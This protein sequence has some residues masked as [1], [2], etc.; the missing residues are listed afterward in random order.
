MNQ[1]TT[2]VALLFLAACGPLPVDDVDE[3]GEDDVATSIF[4]D[5]LRRV[6]LQPQ[7]AASF[8][9]DVYSDDELRTAITEAVARSTTGDLPQGFGVRIMAPISFS[10]PYV[11]PA[12]VPGFSI[13]GNNILMTP[14]ASVD[15]VFVVETYFVRIES[16]SVY[17]T[18]PAIVVGALVAT[19]AGT[20]TTGGSLSMS[21]M[22][23][24]SAL[25]RI[26]SSAGQGGWTV[27]QCSHLLLG[28]PS[29]G[30]G[31]SLLGSDSHIIQGNSTDATEA[32]QWFGD[33]VVVNGNTFSG[34]ATGDTGSSSAVF[35]GNVMGFG[36]IDVSAADGLN[37]I[38]G[39]T[40][41]GV[42]TNNATDVVG[43]NT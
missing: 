13:D 20:T 15:A 37:A 8:I 35:S 25:I 24:A 10:A 16:V 23:G 2:L 26:A 12:P 19:T 22:F 29:S 6:N 27:S 33:G 41:C 36:D 3:T 4:R 11:I 40:Q 42:I 7:A 21:R 5:N 34:N 9:R 14:L 18:D 1:P 31:I 38:F 32:I 43:L 39:N 30:A 17:A 28:A